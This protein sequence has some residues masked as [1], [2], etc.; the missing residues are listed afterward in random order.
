MRNQTILKLAAPLIGAFLLFTMQTVVFANAGEDPYYGFGTA[1]G[2]T[3][4]VNLNDYHSN[5]WDRFTFDY[6]FHSGGSYRY[7]LGK[8]TT[9]NG[10]VQPDVYSSNIRRDKN[11]AYEP[12]SYG[13]LSGNVA[14]QPTN[15]LF[16]QPADSVYWTT[17]PQTDT[18]VILKYDTLQM[19]V[20]AAAHDNPMN[21]YNVGQTGVLKSTSTGF[22][23]PTSIK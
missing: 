10:H 1:N 21:M 4:T 8:P 19:G 6:Q 5:S 3:D 2:R 20:N 7:E 18:N 9:F 16:A 11:V 23:P 15:Y 17:F 22:L 13:V 12:P 14:T